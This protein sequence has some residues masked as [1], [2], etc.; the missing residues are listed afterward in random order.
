MNTIETKMLPGE[1]WWGG[2]VA[3]SLEQPYDESSCITRQLGKQGVNQSAPL[4]I[5]SKG[6]YIHATSPLKI[7][8]L[9]AGSISWRDEGVFSF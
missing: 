9:F 2:S 5:S 6:R 4:Y 1:K 8:K 7:R 3:F